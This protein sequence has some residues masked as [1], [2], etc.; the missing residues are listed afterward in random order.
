M[1]VQVVYAVIASAKNLYFEELW[2]SV[3]SLRIYDRER[4]I[5]ILCDK[6]T[7]EYISSFPKFVKLI[8]D[9]IVVDLP[10]DYTP[11]LRSREIK[12]TVRRYVKGPF[13][14][15]DTDTIFAGNLT[16]ID[17]LDCDIAA[18]PEYHLELNDSPFKNYVYSYVHDAFGIGID[19]ARFWY[20]SGI[21]FCNDTPKG[22]EFYNRWNKNWKFSAFERNNSQDQPAFFKSNLEMDFVMS[23][24]PG[25]YNCQ[26]C[27][28]LKYLS[29]SR[30]IHFLHFDTP[31]N[32]DF[33]PF[34]N[35][36]IYSQ[37]KMDKGISPDVEE[38][39][40][41]VRQAYATP[42]CVVGWSTMS[43]LMSPSAQIFEKVYNHGGVASWLMMKVAILIDFVYSITKRK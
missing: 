11:K 18:V 30:I 15:V 24:L 12:T 27:M 13:L 41:N 31:S 38:K 25:E 17:T 8:T 34:M 32:R 19:G 37:I 39:I 9:I 5:H 16:G 21:V 33:N 2:S 1:K 22:Y 4:E 42:S 35:K 36:S 29:T 23:Q 7:A 14:F 40:R 3:F 43:F 6:N 26:V 28:S 10:D 20:N